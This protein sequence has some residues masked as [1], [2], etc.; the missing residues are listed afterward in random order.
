MKQTSK[1]LSSSLLALLFLVAAFVLFFEL[2]EPAYGNLQ[3]LKGQ[4]LSDQ[5][6]LSSEQQLVTSAK[7]L[8]TA[9]QSEGQAQANLALAMP[10]G[11]DVSGALAQVYGIAIANGISVSS[12]GI[13]T[14]VVQ[15][16]PPGAM[17][18]S[19]PLTASQIVAPIGTISFQVSATG[20]Y[21]DLTELLQGSKR[22][23][24]SLT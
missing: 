19:T 16:P 23:S 4:E 11:P 17:S 3:M 22:I 18:G 20:S 13:S 8:L 24:G 12:I 9:Y 2:I 21:E 14:P 5:Q 6:F 7:N 15:L 10:S 1:R